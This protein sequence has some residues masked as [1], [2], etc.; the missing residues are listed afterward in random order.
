[1]GLGNLQR[2][3]SLHLVQNYGYGNRN[4]TTR[5]PLHLLTQ[6]R[7]ATL[8]QQNHGR[9]HSTAGNRLI[10]LSESFKTDNTFTNLK[11]L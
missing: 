4:T 1:M 10:T 9:N 3:L 5:P 11:H 6:Q 8:S 7:L 2:N